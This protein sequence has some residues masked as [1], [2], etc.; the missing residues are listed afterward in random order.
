MGIKINIMKGEHQPNTSK[1][2]ATCSSFDACSCRAQIQDPYR[3]D[4]D[5]ADPR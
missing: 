2:Q 1:D 3:D 4:G 5:G